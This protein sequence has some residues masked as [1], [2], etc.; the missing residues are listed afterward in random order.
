MRGVFE[1]AAFER[2]QALIA[3]HVRALVDGHGE[4]AVAEQRAG[5]LAVLQ[6]RR[7]E[8]RI[9]AQPVRRLEIDDQERHRTVGLRL[10]D[11]AAVE[12]QR[13]AEQRVSTMASPSSLPTG[14]G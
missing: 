5:I 9:G 13:R 6:P 11:E 4:M 2:D 3:A 12:F 7:V 8:P 1:T 14:G 10:Q